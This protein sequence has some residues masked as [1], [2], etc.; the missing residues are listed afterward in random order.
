MKNYK[1]RVV[2]VKVTNMGAIDPKYFQ[3]PGVRRALE[4]EIAAS[5]S[6]SE[7]VKIPAGVRPIWSD[8]PITQNDIKSFFKRHKSKFDIALI[9]LNLLNAIAL[10]AIATYV[11]WELI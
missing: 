7:K 6:S 11:V 4:R 10:I 8:A 3:L 9:I 2:A 1:K 5:I